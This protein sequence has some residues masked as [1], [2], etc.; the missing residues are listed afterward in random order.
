MPQIPVVSS[1]TLLKLAA[2]TIEYDNYELIRKYL[3]VDIPINEIVTNI[4]DNNSISALR[5][6]SSK[7]PYYD[8]M[9][10]ANHTI[11]AHVCLNGTVEMVDFIVSFYSLDQTKSNILKYIMISNSIEH[12]N[13]PVCYYLI[14]KFASVLRQDRDQSGESDIIRKLYSTYNLDLV[15]FALNLLGLTP[16]RDRTIS[17]D[18]KYIKQLIPQEM[19]TFLQEVN[20]YPQD[21]G[22]L[23]NALKYNDRNRALEIMRL[24]PRGI[25]ELD[26][27]MCGYTDDNSQ[28]LFDEILPMIIYRPLHTITRS[29]TISGIKYAQNRGI[30]SSPHGVWFQSSC[31]SEV[32]IYLHAHPLEILYA[33]LRENN[34]KKI[35]ELVCYHEDWKSNE[36]DTIKHLAFYNSIRCLMHLVDL[37][38]ISVADILLFIEE[39][40]ENVNVPESLIQHFLNYTTYRNIKLSEDAKHMLNTSVV[41]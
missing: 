2:R 40:Q 19:L 6:F 38:L 10:N 3:D 36:M 8:Y 27:L 35:K 15:K 26:D 13:I 39:N 20:C 16:T 30:F 17:V 22:L 7:S 5:A 41:Y 32:L 29:L 1:Y 18:I 21:V 24:Y 12:I 23:I 11:C 34:M 25:Y 37:N 4:I 9:W 28:P 14:A 33:L 31:S